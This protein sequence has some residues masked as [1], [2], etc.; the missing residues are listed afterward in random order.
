MKTALWK[1]LTWDGVLVAVMLLIGAYIRFIHIIEYRRGLNNDSSL[2]SWFLGVVVLTLLV[3]LWVLVRLVV[4]FRRDGWL[5]RLLRL[6]LVLAWFGT[7]RGGVGAPP[8]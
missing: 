2:E 4:F 7:L 8:D 3:G 5:G 1:R 6:F